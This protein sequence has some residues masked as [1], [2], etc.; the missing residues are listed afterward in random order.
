MKHVAFTLAAL[1][2]GAGTAFAASPA[3]PSAT[4][5][6]IKSSYHPPQ[7]ITKALNLLEAK[8]YGSFRNFKAD[9]RDFTATVMKNG[10]KMT[11]RIDPGSNQ[12]TAS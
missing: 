4:H 5:A 1:V 8:G 9:G 7:R 3:M 12:V 2:L 10:H 6:V 11:V